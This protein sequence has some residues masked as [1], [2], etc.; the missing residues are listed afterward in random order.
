MNR[1]K[2]YRPPRNQRL[3]PELYAQAGRVCFITVRA[4]MRQ[5]PFG[6]DRLNQMIIDALAEEEERQNCAVFT[7]CLMPDHLHFLVSPRQ[8]GV[9]VLT[10]TDRFKGRTTSAS[11]QLGWR[12]KLWQPRYYD[13]I[14]RTEESLQA[15]AA[16]ILNNPVRKNLV[17]QPELWP[18]SGQLNPLPL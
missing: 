15:I 5:S 3:A 1:D 2:P 7:Y 18:W 11:W 8:D 12:N 13:H 9:S 14:V 17:L 4:Y 6:P 10:F 16:Y